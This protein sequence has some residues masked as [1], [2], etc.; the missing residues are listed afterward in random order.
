[1]KLTYLFLLI[2]LFS[3]AQ[4]KT[5]TI[6]KKNGSELIAKTYSSKVKYLKVTA[7]DGSIIE[8][9][10]EQLEKIEY[11]VKEKR[12]IKTVTRHYVRISKRNGQLMKLLASGK[13]NM[14]V[15]TGAG[16]AGTVS[17][18]YFALRNEEEIATMIGSKNFIAPKNFKKIVLDYFKDCP[19]AITKIEKKFKRKKVIELV[20]FYN[21]NCNE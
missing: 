20:D 13:C 12:E 8:L 5:Y 6:T 2:T 16:G 3:F 9:P 21:N 14:Y 19:K 11:E 7:T 17:V 18:D 1:M 15:S 4:K 10:Y